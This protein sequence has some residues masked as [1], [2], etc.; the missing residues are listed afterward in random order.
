MITE[1]HGTKV[2]DICHRYEVLEFAGEDKHGNDKWKCRC[3]C[4]SVRVVF[5]NGLRGGGS[6]SCGCHKLEQITTHGRSYSREY[7]S[8][9]SMWQRCS[10]PKAPNY[11]K[12]GARGITVCD[13]W[14][15]FENFYA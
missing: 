12:Y 8:W 3:K 13:R 9:Q 11:Y 4:G 7:K 6:K 14:K 15:S 5:G 1:K 10:N 2:G